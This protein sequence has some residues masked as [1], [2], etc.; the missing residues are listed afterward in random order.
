MGSF[1][2][3]Y[4]NY[5]KKKEIDVWQQAKP[6]IMN[7]WDKIDKI[8]KNEMF[9]KLEKFSFSHIILDLISSSDDH[10]V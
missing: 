9:D 10:I 8:R 5:C 1:E 3:L 7:S 2:I 4:K 6:S